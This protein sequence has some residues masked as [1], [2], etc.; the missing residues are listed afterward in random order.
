VIST[1]TVEFSPGDS[2]KLPNPCTVVFMGEGKAVVV[3]HESDQP[4]EAE[5]TRY[6]RRQVGAEAGWMYYRQREGQPFEVWLRVSEEWSES[7]TTSIE[8]LRHKWTG[9]V[10]I[11]EISAS[12]LPTEARET[13]TT[14]V[15]RYYRRQ[16]GPDAEWR[17]YR[18]LAGGALE[19]WFH[20]NKA[21]NESSRTSIEALRHMWTDK[22]K[23]EEITSAD[24][25][26][27]IRP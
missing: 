25:P 23:I 26:A 5:Q 18:Q 10:R 13:E 7:S 9:K 6:Y 19:T 14:P 24:L 15:V 1:E 8:K 20:W 2:L 4:A 21:W 11:E 22:I 27:G 3:W 17:Y 16:I 12:E